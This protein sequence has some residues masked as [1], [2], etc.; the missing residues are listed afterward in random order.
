M[1]IAARKTSSGTLT[2]REQLMEEHQ[3][4]NALR[5][6]YPAV[7]QLRIELIFDDP[8]ARTSPS[9][10]L[11][12]LFPAA[13]GFFRFACPCADCDGEFDLTDTVAK[14]M[15]NAAGRTRASTLSGRLV[16]RGVRFRNVVTHQ[17]PCT[18]HLSYK[19]VSEPIRADRTG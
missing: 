7:E 3:R 14:L 4:T 12:T 5:K 6:I 13:P 18:I 8:A 19:L 11:H 10:Q 16:C 1:K 2:R 9:S 15:T 17:A